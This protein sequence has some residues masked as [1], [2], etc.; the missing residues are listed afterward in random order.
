[1]NIKTI[2]VDDEPHARRYLSDLLKADEEIELLDELKNGREAIAY[3][4]SHRVDLVFLDIH[5]PGIN[6]LEVMQQ[7]PASNSAFIVFTTAYDQYAI[8]AFEASA[9]DYLLKPFDKQRLTKSLDR[10]KEQL[11]LRK[12]SD[13]HQKM[14][15]L[16]QDF[17]DARSP[18]LTEFVMKDRGFEKVIKAK[19]IL[20]IEASSVYAELHTQ[21]ERHLYRVAL[22]LLDKELSTDF[23]RIH[24]SIIV[25]TTHILKTSYLNNNTYL[26][27]MSNG[28]E[29]ISS[30]SYKTDIMHRLGS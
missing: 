4:E 5:M 22:N 2:I 19:D 24:R 29:L 6:G 17:Q 21:N 16:Y 23:L 9:M 25:N 30:R 14:L 13:F 8:T 11:E 28:K 3:L 18:Q 10:V 1:M 12:D 27:R 26:F 7:I 15:S 20:W